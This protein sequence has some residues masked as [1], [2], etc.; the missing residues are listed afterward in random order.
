[1]RN[2]WKGHKVNPTKI[3]EAAKL[4]YKALQI[5]YATDSEFKRNVDKKLSKSRSKGAGPFH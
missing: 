1:M 5:R 4:G 3:V 2:A